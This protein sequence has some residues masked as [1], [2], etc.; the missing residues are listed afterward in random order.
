MC[1][2]DHMEVRETSNIPSG[3]GQSLMGSLAPYVRTWPEPEE[4]W[5]EIR[6]RAWQTAIRDAA[7]EK[8]GD[9]KT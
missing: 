7:R 5:E 3:R 1:V 4:T 8:Y 2:N 9:G 6:E